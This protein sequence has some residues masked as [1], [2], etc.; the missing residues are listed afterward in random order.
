MGE[1]RLDHSFLSVKNNF[2]P[3]NQRVK[4]NAYKIRHFSCEIICLSEILFHQKR[5]IETLKTELTKFYL[6]TF[7][8]VQ[9]FSIFSIVFSF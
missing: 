9:F 7:S 8:T 2:G 6:D 3:P 1:L 4:S 5:S